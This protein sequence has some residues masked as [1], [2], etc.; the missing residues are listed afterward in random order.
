MLEIIKDIFSREIF[1]RRIISIAELMIKNGV[2]LSDDYFLNYETKFCGTLG[3]KLIP[4]FAASRASSRKRKLELEDRESVNKKFLPEDPV[5][6]LDIL[7]DVYRANGPLAETCAFIKARYEI[8]TLKL[9]LVAADKESSE[10]AES[11]LKTIVD[12]LKEEEIKLRAEILKLTRA[13]KLLKFEMSKLT[14]V[15]KQLR[16]EKSQ[17]QKALEM[18]D[19]NNKRLKL[20]IVCL[21]KMI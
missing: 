7:L 20:G 19:H 3:E 11:N 4:Q 1:S 21:H 18:S 17:F 2:D 13:N 8:L 10:R 15:T 6:E 5:K 16:L 12:K 9:K 14:A